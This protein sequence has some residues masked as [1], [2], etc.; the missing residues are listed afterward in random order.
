MVT[1]ARKF[2]FD[3]LKSYEVGGRVFEKVH[4][5]DISKLQV[6]SLGANDHMLEKLANG[7][8]TVYR[9]YAYLDDIY[10]G[11]SQ[12]SVQAEMKEDKDS[13]K[14]LWKMLIKKDGDDNFKDAF[15]TNLE[16]YFEDTPVVLQRYQKGEYGNKPK[17]KGLG[18]KMVGL[19]MQASGLD[20]LE[21]DAMIAAF[22]DY[23]KENLTK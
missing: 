16:K 21:T 3:D 1:K 10:A 2:R 4:Y 18:A 19:A 7:K 13:S 23:N 8:I 6:K 14:R 12:A 22:N 15:A 9:Y 20:H 5:M 11:N 17:K